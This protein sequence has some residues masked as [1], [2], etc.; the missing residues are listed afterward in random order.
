MKQKPLMKN[1]KSRALYNFKG[2]GEIDKGTELRKLD[3]V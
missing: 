1:S 2:K 3:T